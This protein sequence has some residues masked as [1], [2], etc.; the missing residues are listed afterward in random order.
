M[1]PVRLIEKGVRALEG[2]MSLVHREQGCLH[3]L[4]VRHHRIVTLSYRYDKCRVV[5]SPSADW[6]HDQLLED[7]GVRRK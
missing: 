1:Q 4:R 2:H 6:G 5:Q 7:V 3:A